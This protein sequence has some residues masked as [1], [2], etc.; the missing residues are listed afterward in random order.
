[1]RTQLAVIAAVAVATAFALPTADVRSPATAPGFAEHEQRRLR[2]HFD[3][4]DVELR[5]VSGS[6][7]TSAQRQSRDSL[8]RWLNEYREQGVFPTNDRFAAHTPFF[9]D[10]N[11]VLCAMAYLIARSGRTDIVDRIA[12]TRNNHYIDQLSD[13]VALG[14]WLDSVGL[15]AKEA[16]R[17]QPT[18]GFT[19]KEDTSPMYVLGS[20]VTG[21]PTLVVGGYNVFSPCKA[22]GVM[23]LLTGTA[24][25]LLGAAK[26]TTDG[27]N[28]NIAR[29][30][31]AIGAAGFAL[32]FRGLTRGRS[33]AASNER[34]SRVG[35]LMNVSLAPVMVPDGPDRPAR[36]GIGFRAV[37]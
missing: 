17:I 1:M 3:S 10:S 25:I 22:S 9:R 27:G 18:Y 7:F 37:F 30:N 6:E 14:A 26:V 21:V 13:D 5:S 16:A 31:V 35:P 15:S 23:G 2:S 4:V 12:R 34:G 36:G 24:S 11:G 32:S 8:I 19:G 20:I 33:P 28:R 29:A